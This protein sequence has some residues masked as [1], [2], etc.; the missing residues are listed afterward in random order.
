MTTMEDLDPSTPL[1]SQFRAETGSIVLMNTFFVPR[2]KIEEFLACWQRDSAFMKSRPGFISAQLHR[3]TAGSHLLMNIAVWESTEALARAHADPEFRKRASQHPD[4][5][6]VYPHIYQ[7]I[8]V[9]G[10]CTG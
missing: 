6:V 9:E 3:G 7:K 2:D 5:I 4:G 10:I 1:A 8:A